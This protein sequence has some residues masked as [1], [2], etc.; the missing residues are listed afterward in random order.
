MLKSGDTAS[1]QSN[2]FLKTVSATDQDIETAAWTRSV[3]VIGEREGYLLA[4]MVSTQNRGTD[5]Y[6]ARL[7]PDG[8]TEW[9]KSIGGTGDDRAY[10]LIRTRAGDFVMAGVSNNKIYLVRING[11]G[12]VS[13]ERKYLRDGAPNYQLSDQGYAIVETP[14]G[15]FAVTGQTA[16]PGDIIELRTKVPSI[17]RVDEDGTLLWFKKYKNGGEDGYG[18]AITLRADGGFLITGKYFNS[19]AFLEVT[20]RGMLEEISKGREERVLYSDIV[21][22]DNGEGYMITGQD[23]KI[24]RGALVV[25]KLSA[26]GEQLWSQT[27]GGGSGEA[28]IRAQDGNFIVA[29]TKYQKGGMIKDLVTLIKI[30]QEGNTLWETTQKLAGNAE[31]YDLQQ[32]DSGAIIATGRFEFPGWRIP[33]FPL[34][35]RADRQGHIA[36][37]ETMLKPE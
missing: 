9:E 32:T 36:N 27:Y 29:G 15:G 22:I 21:H 26:S 17:L 35:L 33:V 14:D 31:L 30:D 8:Q 34:I 25:S 18:S 2:I 11:Q 13:W 5:I 20:E 7:D 1:Q 37:I 16:I 12:Q 6:L 4:G 3:A 19:S 28:I 24:D 23:T 10:D